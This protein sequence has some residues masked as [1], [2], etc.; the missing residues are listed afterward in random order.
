MPIQALTLTRARGRTPA[1]APGESPDPCASCSCPGP[2]TA[3]ILPPESSV[4]VRRP[5]APVWFCTGVDLR[6]APGQRVGLIGE[7]GTGSPL[8]CGLAGRSASDTDAGTIQRQDDLATARPGTGLRRARHGRRRAGP[9]A[10]A[11]ARRA[12]AEVERPAGAPRPTPTRAYAAAYARALELALAHDAWDAD[13]RGRLAAARLGMDGLAPTGR[14]G[15]LSGGERTRLALAAVMATRPGCVLLD[16]P[17]NHLDDAALDVL[18]VPAGPAGRGALGQPRPGLPRRGR[19]GARGPRP[20]ASAP[21]ARAGAGSPAAGAPTRSRRDARRRWEEAYPPSRPSS[22]AAGRT[23][24][25]PRR[26]PQ[27]GADRQRQFIHNFKGGKVDRTWPGARRPPAAASRRRS[28][29]R[30]A[31]RPRRCAGSRLTAAGTTARPVPVRD[32]VIDGRSGWP[33]W[34]CR[35]ES[36]CWSAGATGRASRACSP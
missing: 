15:T 26:R 7:N 19:H 10:L 9:D 8:C 16:E 1:G 30:C 24:S 22:T 14:V 2:G 4:L 31:S 13:R 32:L 11:P 25:A 12:V 33:G 29:A 18:R 34:T 6:A 20:G 23:R 21:T 5:S 27:P 35:R 28:A 3:P 17:T 36:T